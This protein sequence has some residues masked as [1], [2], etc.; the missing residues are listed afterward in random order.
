MFCRLMLF[1]P[2]LRVMVFTGLCSARSAAWWSVTSSLLTNPTGTEM[3]DAWLECP[4]CGQD[5]VQIG[6]EDGM[7]THNWM[8]I[9]HACN[10]YSPRFTNPMS[11]ANFVRMKCRT[12]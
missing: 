4:N 9:C 10:S 1:V 8:A 6:V 5:A 3:E 2:T 11:V 12:N 7:H